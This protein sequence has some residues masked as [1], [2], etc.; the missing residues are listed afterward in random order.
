MIFNSL[1]N[2]KAIL[3]WECF[4]K[5]ML[6]FEILSR[7]IETLGYGEGFELRNQYKGCN[8]R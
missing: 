5:E 2:K 6:G 3:E 4:I 1:T 8:A 7:K